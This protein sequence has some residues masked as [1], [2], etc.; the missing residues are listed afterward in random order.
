MSTEKARR[1]E[2]LDKLLISLVKEQKPQTVEELV[3]MIP[4]RCSCSKEEIIERISLMQDRGTLSLKRSKASVPTTFLGFVLSDSSVWF[5]IVIILAIS[6]VSLIAITPENAFPFVYARYILG[7][8]YALFLPGYCF[9][10]AFLT[11]KL[12]Y[13]EQVVLSLGL[14]IVF[15]F[16]TGLLLNY[17]P[18]GLALTPIVLSLLI[19][20]LIFSLTALCREYKAERRKFSQTREKPIASPIS[21]HDEVVRLASAHPKITRC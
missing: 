11:Q 20:T 1:G 6:T 13:M 4:E 9:E 3:E 8:V 12:D 15:I 17:L 5:W 21:K 7:L 10:R 16:L 18:W 19:V 2:E 14:S